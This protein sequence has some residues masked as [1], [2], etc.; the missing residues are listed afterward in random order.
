MTR[1]K[2]DHPLL[3]LLLL[4]S[5][6]LL[7]TQGCSGWQHQAGFMSDTMLKLPVDFTKMTVSEGP[8]PCVPC[9]LTDTGN[10]LSDENK[11]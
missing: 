3:L 1:T 2:S 9:Q 5:N 10:L 4:V 8:T 6:N 11:K 7:L